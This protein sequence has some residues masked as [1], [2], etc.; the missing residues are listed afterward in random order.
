MSS[1]KARNV[2]L[3]TFVVLTIIF[4]SLFAYE[5]IQ[6]QQLKT[7]NITTSITTV[8]S[9]SSTTSTPVTTETLTT[10]SII[11]ASATVPNV[12]EEGQI[13]FGYMG[14]YT[15]KKLGDLAGDAKFIFRNVTFSSIPSTEIAT[16][17]VIRN[18]WVTFPDG[19]SEK[20]GVGWCMFPKL[21]MAFTNHSN[22]KAG[23]I[24]SPGDYQLGDTIISSPIVE[25]FYLLV[26]E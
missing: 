19:T 3:V 24:L 15:Y 8:T 7:P 1:I 18:I 21:D 16:G 11:T 12:P 26:S 13:N 10:T 6:V 23:V 9:T 25:G 17:C 5:F 4:G 20:I 2:L 14:T 22:P